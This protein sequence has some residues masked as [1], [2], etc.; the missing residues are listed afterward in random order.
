MKILFVCNANIVRSFMAERVLKRLLTS[1]GIHDVDV[2]SAG[3]LDMH[4]A[5]ADATARQVL[6]EHGIN[7]ERHQS[8]LLTEA[9][10]EE[11]DLIVTMEKKQLQNIRDQYPHAMN[12]LRLLKSYLSNPGYGETEGDVKDPYG[13]SIFHYR[14]CY[15]EISLAMEELIKCI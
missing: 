15:A 7:D 6:Q 8:R 1:R 2:S 11:A 13:R 10:I 3:L 4:G 5:A 9:M 12:K 14:L